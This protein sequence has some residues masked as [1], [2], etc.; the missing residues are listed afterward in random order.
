MQQPDE[1][2]NPQPEWA[3][4]EDPAG[5]HAGGNE[6][7]TNGNRKGRVRLPQTVRD[8]APF[9][10]PGTYRS[11]ELAIALKLPTQERWRVRE[12]ARRGMPHEFDATGHLLMDGSAFALWVAW[13]TAARPRQ[14]LPPGHVWCMGCN[15]P[16][17]PQNKRTQIIHGRRYSVA[18]CQQGHRLR[19]WIGRE[20]L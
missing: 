14:Q 1:T 18:E 8:H 13:Q 11:R 5:M 10:L 16:Q 20:I 15:R 7:R 4:D 6:P 17:V 3:L 12:W 9:L 2:V 19:H